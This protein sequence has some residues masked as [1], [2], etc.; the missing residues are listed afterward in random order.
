MPTLIVTLLAF[1]AG[2]AG[3]PAA[4]KKAL[5]EITPD[6]VREHVE[7]LASDALAGRDTPSPGLDTA[8]SY[9][10]EQFEAAGL[11]VPIPA[12][13]H[14]GWYQEAQWNTGEFDPDKSRITRV[15]ASGNHATLPLTQ[16]SVLLPRVLA[17]L[18][19]VACRVMT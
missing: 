13:D 1:A 10:A 9:I 18:T 17:P 5:D 2:T 7:F 8:A 6:L 4:V 12:V 16:S 11:V 14:A 3:P 19:S 15:D